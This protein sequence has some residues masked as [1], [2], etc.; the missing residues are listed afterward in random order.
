MTPDEVAR[1]VLT[2]V[3]H[4]RVEIT[5]A[6]IMERIADVASAVSPRLAS[7]IARTIGVHAYLRRVADA[8]AVARHADATEHG[9]DG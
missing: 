1:A 9:Q 5:V 2:C 6:P 3:R 4:D 8:R 7:W